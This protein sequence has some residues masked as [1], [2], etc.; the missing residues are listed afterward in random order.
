MELR[1]FG[2]TA[3]SVERALIVGLIL[4]GWALILVFRL[5]QLQ[6]ISHDELEKRARRQQEKLVPVEAQRGSIYDRNGNLLAISSASHSV[7]V[8]PRRIPDK[9]TAAALLAGVLSLDAKRLE[10]SLEVAASSRHHNGYFVV[11]PHL[12]EE[13]AA[14]LRAMNLDWLEIRNGSLRTYPNDDVAAHVIGN[15]NSEN[16]GVS[17]VELKLNKELAGSKGAL[18]I[19][20]DGRESSYAAEIVKTATPGKSVGLTIDRAL[21]YVAKEALREAVI[22]NHADHGSLVAMNPNTGEILALE[23]YPTYDLNEHLL[24]GEKAKGR[25]DLA[26]VAPFE[27][28]SVFKIIT[29]SAALETTNLRPQS[30][31]NCGNGSISIFGR[32]VHDH[33]AYSALSMADVLAFSSNVG[34]I[35]IGMQVGNKNLYDYIRRFGFGQRT[36]IELPAEAPGLLRPLKRWQPTSIGS[37]PMG[38]ELAVTSVQLAQAGSVIANGGLLVHP[39]LLAWEQAQG[40]AK[41]RVEY[42][43]PARVL[44]ARTVLT[45]RTMMRRVVTDVGGTGHRLHVPGYAFAGK[46]G[47]AQI[48]DYAHRIYTHK[49]NASFLG[50]APMEKPS[51]VVVATVSGTSG[52]AGWGGTAAGPA[53]EKVMAAAL[54]REGAVRDAPEEIEELMAAKE[55]AKKSKDKGNGNDTDDVAVAEVNPPTAE[56]MQQASGDATGTGEGAPANLNPNAPKVPNFVGKT[57][58]DVMQQAAANGIDLEMTGEGMARRQMP[59]AGAVLVPG[60]PIAVRF[61][62]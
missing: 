39:R 50:F 35:R 30:I 36:G 27:P 7:V 8:N 56:E 49:Y 1:P 3:K 2:P 62:R 37:V 61:A 29:L 12:T 44:D 10:A 21:Q 24:P 25:E 45:M 23:N 4:L 17:G 13:Q 14:T 11:S 28:G 16:S 47:T 51:M 42:P 40:D 53:F 5:F 22:K 34:A 55:K 59:A 58:K 33:K 6:V 20:R 15:I 32:V 18:R 48:Y 43:A 38:H 57:V 54:A 41:I 31:I 52:M 9:G 60:E 26:V 46:T 19:E